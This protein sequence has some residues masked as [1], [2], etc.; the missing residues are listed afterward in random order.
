MRRADRQ[1]VLAALQDSQLLSVLA[2][3]DSSSIPISAL[4]PFDVPVARE[5]LDSA[6][7]RC[8]AAIA[9]AVYR[10]T[11]QLRAALQADLDQTESDTR[12]PLTSR[13]PRRREFLDRLAQQLRQLQRLS[14]FAE[15]TRR[16]ILGCGP[17]NAVSADP[18]YASAYGLGLAGLAS[19]RRRP[20]GFRASLDF[21]DMGNL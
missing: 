21:S 14:P 19:W 8:I 7:N 16:E 12:T 17:L 10:R 1:T 15:V 5:T 20:A 2:D 6:G 13:W 11:L 4:P 18:A 9:H 3:G